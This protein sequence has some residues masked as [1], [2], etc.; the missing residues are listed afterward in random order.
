MKNL[1]EYI[2]EGILQGIES[3]LAHGDSLSEPFDYLYNELKKSPTKETYNQTMS[4]VVSI[5]ST[6][7]TSDCCVMKDATKSAKK[8][9]IK[10]G[11]AR[12]C[13]YKEKYTI[14]VKTDAAKVY[15]F[16][17]R[18]IK[19]GF[20][21]FGNGTYL[22]PKTAKMWWEGINKREN[23]FAIEMRINSKI[24]KDFVKLITMG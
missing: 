19:A 4:L 15:S 17:L 22:N 20:P 18:N 5:L 1:S 13:F 2:N 23:E 24:H 8:N 3:T 21:Y 11:F 12:D 9:W 10:I 7:N 14:I 16:E 6:I